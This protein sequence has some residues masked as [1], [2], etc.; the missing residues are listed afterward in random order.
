[1]LRKDSRRRCLNII[2]AS[3]YAPQFGLRPGSGKSYTPVFMS[4]AR[5]A[6]CGIWVLSILF[7]WFRSPAFQYREVAPPQEIMD[8]CCDSA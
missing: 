2:H 1:M 4:T 3:H 5:I 7:P 8:C 6:S